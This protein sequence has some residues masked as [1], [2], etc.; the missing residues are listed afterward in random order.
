MRNF[1]F[2]R[3]S[4]QTKILSYTLGLVFL[5]LLLLTGVYY[6]LEIKQTE[7]HIGTMA[8]NVAKS[9]AVIPEVID[10]FEH[11]DPSSIIQPIAERIRQE[12]GAEFIVVG[13]T[14]D[15]RYSHPKEER[16]GQTMVGG[17]NELALVYGESYIS[18]AEGSLG[19][20]LRGKT[21]V[22]NEQQ[23]IIG[24]VSVGFLIGH[25]QSVFL[26]DLKTF[27]G[28]ALLVFTIGTVGSIILARS[29]RKD[30]LG[31][32]PSEIASLYR[33]RHAI[34]QSVKEG[35]VAVD[36][37]GTVTLI[38]QSAKTMLGITGEA[39]GKPIE[40]LFPNT[41]MHRVLKTGENET[42]QE[43]Q[44][45]NHSVIVNRTPIQEAGETVGVVASFRDRTEVKQMVN[46]LSEVKKYSQDLRAQTHEY[47]NKLYT[48][49][50]LLQIGKVD[51]AIAF[52]H[53]EA[54]AHEIQNKILFE[55]IKDP[56]IQAI[57]LGKLSKASEQKIRFH[58]NEE[59]S[60]GAAYLEADT[61]S[62]ITIFGNLLDNAFEAVSHK[63]EKI[64][65]FFVTDIGH[66]LVFEV[67]DN[68]TGLNKEKMNEL[69]MRGYSTKNGT[70]RGF[71][72]SLVKE[73]IDTLGGTIEAYNPNTGGAVFTVFLPKM[74][75][76]STD[77]ERFNR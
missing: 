24:V 45:K 48:I 60:L 73:A 62:L 26:Q 42:N 2:Q 49:S 13:N 25:I 41:Q 38:N 1:N 68:G 17:D 8:L 32:E 71:G 14:E 72:L 23:D 27:A 9:V 36:N 66:D 74:R 15:I 6:Y 12:V 53:K 4:L 65:T 47:T 58:I 22:F 57:L 5:V 59:S 61:S 44:L 39:V 3:I 70:N 19:T 50:G 20:S 77:H 40:A 30:T 21:P 31:L 33:E 37:M 75:R 52:I 29:I 46:T 64:V 28:W 35:I 51:D 55:Q 7:N 67:A 10:A 76:R 43:I 56:T 69:F 16:I 18:K 11:E 34:L 63:A 54:Q